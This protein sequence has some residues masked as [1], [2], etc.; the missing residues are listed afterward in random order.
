MDL[1]GRTDRR[2]DAMEYLQ[3]QLVFIIDRIY[4][5]MIIIRFQSE[6]S[7][8]VDWISS[9]VKLTL[10]DVHVFCTSLKDV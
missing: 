4:V 3:L 9:T 8:L 6:C 2:T 10:F 7:G 1:D 5:E